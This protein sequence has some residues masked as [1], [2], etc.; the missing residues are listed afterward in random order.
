METAPLKRDIAELKLDI[1]QKK[2]KVA[3]VVPVVSRAA[4]HMPEAGALQTK[5]ES[6]LRRP[7]G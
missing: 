2:A 3:K 7:V 5:L 4:Q 1:A 6:F